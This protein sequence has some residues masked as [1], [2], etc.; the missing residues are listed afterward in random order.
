VAKPLRSMTGFARLRRSLPEGELVLSLRSVNHRGLDPQFH[1]PPDLEP[2]EMA[3]RK[4]IA[5]R[6]SRGHITVRG[7]FTRSASTA[8]V[9]INQGQLE[10]WI[11]A[12]RDAARRHGLAAEPDLNAVLRIPG[13][14]G[15]GIPEEVGSG[16]ESGVVALFEEALDLLNQERSR[17]GAGTAVVVSEHQQRIRQATGEIDALRAEVLPYLRQRIEERLNE[18]L[19]ASPIDPTRLAQEAALLADR[20]DISEEVSRLRIHSDSLADLL[21]NGGE[22]GKKMEFL[23]QEMHREA[24]TILSKSNHAGEPGRRVAALALSVKSEIEKIR[25]QS[26]NL[27]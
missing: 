7:Y 3:M 17:E 13:M 25:E 6:M 1:M 16:L 2:M 10:A 19:Q 4:L 11:A 5:T 23:A 15:D 12:F 18:M 9:A 20:G 27:E 21:Q 22:A 14:L 8:G 24:N 26:F